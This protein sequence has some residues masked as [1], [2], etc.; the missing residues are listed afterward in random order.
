MSESDREIPEKNVKDMDVKDISLWLRSHPDFFRKYPEILDDMQ[1]PVERTGKRIADFQSYMIERLKSDKQQVLETTQE[2][3]ET[4]RANMTNQSR[5]QKTVIRLLEARTLDEFL[6]ALT[7]D[8]GNIL[9]VDICALIVESN[10]QDIPHVH[11]TGVRV[12]PLGTVDNWMEDKKCLLQD[13]ISGIEAIY[14]GGAGLVQSQLLLKLHI[15]S[16]TPPALMAFGSRD[17]ELFQDGMGTEHV[18][19]LAGV[20]ERCLARFL[21]LG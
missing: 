4:S 17:P 14:G 21:Q 15:S 10:G 20:I 9:G 11:F 19:F 8:T 16:D 7:I 18:R 1:P 3:V 5:I 6:H 2:I 13:H 12:V